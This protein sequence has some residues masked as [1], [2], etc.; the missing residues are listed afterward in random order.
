M[1]V[2]RGVKSGGLHPTGRS[3]LRGRG[4]KGGRGDGGRGAGT[5]RDKNHG[6]G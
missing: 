1:F 3:G 5:S 2:G 4:G 6:W